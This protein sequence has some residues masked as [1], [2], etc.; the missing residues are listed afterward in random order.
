[1]HAYHFNH[2]VFVSKQYLLMKQGELIESIKPRNLENI[3][4]KKVDLYGFY[5][6]HES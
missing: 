1:M 4:H 3:F 5:C 2:Q 6:I